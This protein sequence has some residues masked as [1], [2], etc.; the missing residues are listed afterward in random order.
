VIEDL[1]G[2]DKQLKGESL[3]VVITKIREIL[4]GNYSMLGGAGMGSGNRVVLTLYEVLEVFKVM[5]K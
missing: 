5:M 3:A 4:K 2:L 1:E